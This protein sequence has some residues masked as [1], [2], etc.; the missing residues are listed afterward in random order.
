MFC[1]ALIIYNLDLLCAIIL[2]MVI[3]SSNLSGHDAETL[4]EPFIGVFDSGVGGLSVLAELNI[5]LPGENIVYI[6]DSMHAPYGD[7]APKELFDLTGR[8]C[9]WFKEM[10]AKAIVAA[11]NTV[12]S[13]I[14]PELRALSEPL[15]VFSVLEAGVSGAVET[16]RTNKIAVMATATTI[17]SGS[18]ESK[19]KASLPEAEVTGI[20]CPAFVPLVESGQIEGPKAESLIVE[21][22]AEVQDEEIDTI[23][24]GCT[25]Y[26][27]LIPLLRKHLRAGT[28]IMNPASVFADIIA[29][30]LREKNLLSESRQ[31]SSLLLTTGDISQ[32]A[33]SGASLLGQTPDPVYKLPYQYLER[34]S[35]LN[36][37][38][39][40][41]LATRIARSELK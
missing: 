28:T 24:L 19:I 1:L 31:G 14:M 38:R 10:G 12:S 30:D 15:P 13:T 36:T 34:H 9:L 16:T 41:A 33:R 32:F 21:A 22:C 8:M 4:E 2:V 6:G 39:G 18:F 37:V 17:K 29:S 27:A 20:A 25:H 23:L 11:C 7:R 26:P 3:L 40:R 35:P 5:R